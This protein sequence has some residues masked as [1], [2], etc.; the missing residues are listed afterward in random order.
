VRGW[1]QTPGAPGEIVE[2]RIDRDRRARASFARTPRPDV[3]AV[4]P[5]LGSCAEAG[6]EARFP[7][8]PGDDGAHDLHVVFR[9]ADGRMRT[10]SSTFEWAP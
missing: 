5:A 4:L 1:S 8:L 6:Y 3:A 10:I 7:M 2:I 9:S